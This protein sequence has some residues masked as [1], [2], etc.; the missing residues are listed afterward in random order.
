MHLA[1]SAGVTPSLGK[2]RDHEITGV[3][4]KVV[5]FYLVLCGEDCRD[6]T[7]EFALS[8]L[9]LLSDILIREQD[10]AL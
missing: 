7:A 5:C 3:T 9:Q 1:L 4:L 8:V 6:K 2:S 10:V